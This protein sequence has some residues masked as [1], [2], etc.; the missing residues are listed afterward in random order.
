M[1]QTLLIAICLLS[2]FSCSNDDEVVQSVQ[3]M[4]EEVISTNQETEEPDDSNDNND[5]SDSMVFELGEEGPAGGFIIYVNEDPD[6]PWQYVEA[7]PFD[8]EG[9]IEWGCVSSQIFSG[10]DTAAVGMGFINSTAIVDFHDSLDNYYDNPHQCDPS[11]NGI[12]AAK[13]AFAAQ[14]GGFS[15][16]HLPSRDEGILLYE[17]L[18]ETG[19][20]DFDTQGLYWTS[21]EHP[22]DAGAA[23]AISFD[24]DSGVQPW[25]W[26][27]KNW[28]TSEVLPVHIRAVRYF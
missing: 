16:W 18:F 23:A 14:Y 6:S 24:E 20:S 11:N 15:D 27:G 1:K 12:V 8:I 17:V 9:D 7:A 3:E 4:E 21:T 25:G 22:D 5:N 26:I 13:I 28:D 2:F 10:E 19:L